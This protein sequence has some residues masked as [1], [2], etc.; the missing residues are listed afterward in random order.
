MSHET[1]VLADYVARLLA[2][3]DGDPE[4]ADEFLRELRRAWEEDA[5]EAERLFEGR[6]LV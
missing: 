3:L 1:D 6:K 2:E 5:R 4:T